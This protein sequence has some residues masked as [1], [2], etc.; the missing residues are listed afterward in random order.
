[1]GEN[2]IQ[3]LPLSAFE[4]GE[5][6]ALREAASLLHGLVREGAQ[7]VRGNRAQPIDSFAQ[8]QA[9]L[10]EEAKKGRAI[11]RFKGLG[12][13]NP[14]QLWTPR[15]IRKRGACCR[16]GSRTRSRPTRSSAC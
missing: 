3:V 9:W 2:L 6:R 14:E 4:G 16:C 5:L 7:I 12:E 11:Q 1:M 15:S 8:A 13:M 10:L